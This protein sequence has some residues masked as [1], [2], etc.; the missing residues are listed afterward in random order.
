MLDLR[1]GIFID[2]DKKGNYAVKV[3]GVEFEPDPVKPGEP[4]VFK[5]YASSGNS[6]SSLVCL[7]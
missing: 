3:K 5:I 1:I 6:V 4:A 7:C 2:V